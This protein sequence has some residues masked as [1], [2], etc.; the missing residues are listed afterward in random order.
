M[1]KALEEGD[2][3]LLEKSIGNSL[4]ATACE[5]VP[6]VK[7]IVDKLKAKGLKIVLMTGSGSAVFGLSTDKKL[8]KRIADEMEIENP[9]YYVERTEVLK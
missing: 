7:V 3:E 9:Q 8:I 4:Q 5:L 2:D 6:E 1:I